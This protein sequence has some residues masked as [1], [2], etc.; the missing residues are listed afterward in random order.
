MKIKKQFTKKELEK[1]P[2]LSDPKNL[3]CLKHI[4]SRIINGKNCLLLCIG[5][6]G[7]G[8][9]WLNVRMCELLCVMMGIEFDV[10]RR[11][12]FNY[13]SLIKYINEENPQPGDCSV[14]EELGISMSARRWQ[15]NINFSELL[16]SFRNLRL[17]CFFNVPYK[18]FIDKH[19]RL[20]SHCQIE[21]LARDGS[22]NVCKFFVLQTNPSASTEAK[23][24]YR[25]YLRPIQ[26]NEYGFMVRRPIKK[27]FWNK[28]SKKVRDIYEE[29]KKQFTVNHNLELQKRVEKEEQKQEKPTR[30]GKITDEEV[31]RLMIK[32]LTAKEMAGLLGV[33]E[34]T[35]FRHLARIKALT[36]NTQ[37]KAHTQTI[38]A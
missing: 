34:A 8:K 26:K 32:G 5:A 13:K 22:K 12:F 3:A 4:L 1:Y 15:R 6:T 2:E 7:S 37:D 30:I 25:K 19:A 31:Q 36:Q 9:S 29:M 33:C 16:Q 38:K 10:R 17:I 20:L 14:S 35:I 23:T 27:L 21:L 24:I 18:I 11:V 28:P